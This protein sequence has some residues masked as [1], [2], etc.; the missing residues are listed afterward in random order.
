[1]KIETLEDVMTYCTE[2][3]DGFMRA[4]NSGDLKNHLTG[5]QIAMEKGRILCLLYIKKIIS[6]GGSDEQAIDE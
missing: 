6:N 1:M 3:V 4:Y 2:E 5:R